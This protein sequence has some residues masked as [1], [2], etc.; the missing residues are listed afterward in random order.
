L[1]NGD[2]FNAYQNIGSIKDLSKSLTEELEK[3]NKTPLAEI[4]K[5]FTGIIPIVI[6]VA[7]IVGI[8]VYLFWPTKSSYSLKSGYKFA[9]EKEARRKVLKELI[10]KLSKSKELKKTLE[11]KN[12]EGKKE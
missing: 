8:L 6:I 11:I 2:Y 9:G 7:A 10:E 12:K 3:I 4:T 5:T 1:E